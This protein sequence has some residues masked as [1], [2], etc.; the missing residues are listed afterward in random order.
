MRLM[1]LL[2]AL[3]PPLAGLKGKSVQYTALLTRSYP[4]ADETIEIIVDDIDDAETFK[5]RVLSALKITDFRANRHSRVLFEDTELTDSLDYTELK[6]AKRAVDIMYPQEP[7]PKKLELG[8]PK[9]SIQFTK[10]L[11]GGEVVKLYLHEVESYEELDIAIKAMFSLLDSR[12]A[13]TN[14][15]EQDT[16]AYFKKLDMSTKLKVLNILEILYGRQ[17]QD[18]VVQK[19]KAAHLE[20]TVEAIR[21]EITTNGVENAS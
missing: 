8:S 14:K 16:S 7:L 17:M 13:R 1:L 5:D 11:A 12:L 19:L 6:A 21:N 4:N 3:S 10:L 9:G 20:Q 15:R 18:T 2:L